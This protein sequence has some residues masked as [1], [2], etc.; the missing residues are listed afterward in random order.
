MMRDT[1]DTPA[2]QRIL[3]AGRYL[4]LA[5]RGKWEY[6]VRKNLSG[7]VV[8][9][10]VYDDKIVLCEQYRAALDRQVME[11]PAGLVGDVAGRTGESLA[12]AARRELME[13]TGYRA[14]RMEVI[15]EGVVSPGITDEVITLFNAGGLVR[16]GAGGGD[17][18]ERIIVHEVPLGQI[19]DWTAA[20]SASGKLIDIKIFAALSLTGYA[21]AAP[22][23]V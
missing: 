15:F 3:C 2:E 16:E 20:Q 5:A 19:H 7:I 10:A 6:V 8:I 12:A 23:A 13:E 18:D 22:A 1:G 14:E 4:D 9:L 17:G 11:L 21:P